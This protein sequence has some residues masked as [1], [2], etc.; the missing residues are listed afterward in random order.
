MGSWMIDKNDPA[1]LEIVARAKKLGI[2]GNPDR[3]AHP[4]GK[5]IL[6]DGREV[7]VHV[8]HA[9]DPIITDHINVVMINRKNDPA[10]GKPALPGGFIDP[11]K[12]G[13][14]SAIE[15]AAR[16]A[17][18]EAGIDL[19]EAGATLI[20]TRNMDR[21]FDVRIAIGNKLEEKYGIREGDAFMVSTQAV[22]FH[23]PNFVQTNLTAGSD[24]M[25]G[26]ARP[27][28]IDSLT[29][30]NIGAPDHFD[31]IMEALFGRSEAAGK[32]KPDQFTI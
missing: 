27:V 6:A 30:E 18:E 7:S 32:M 1:R 3:A 17:A 12:G 24:A 29:R 10:K 15:A 28:R 21:P 2:T 23:V 14:E 26:S 13:V 5:I 11:T 8:V 19:E 25:P 20:G 16:E 9:V 22:L 31:M 4:L